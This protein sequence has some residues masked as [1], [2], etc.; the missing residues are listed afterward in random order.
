MAAI[1]SIIGMLKKLRWVA[2]SKSDP[3]PPVN[4]I[5]GNIPFTIMRF[6]NTDGLDRPGRARLSS[7]KQ[8]RFFQAS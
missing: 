6:D 5:G 1:R 3:R 8:L 2:A 7:I 4:R